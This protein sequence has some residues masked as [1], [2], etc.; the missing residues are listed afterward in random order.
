MTFSFTQRI[1]SSSR[2]GLGRFYR[3]VLANNGSVSYICPTNAGIAQLVE[4]NLAK[5]DV[6]GSNPVSRSAPVT[7]GGHSVI[8]P[9]VSYKYTSSLKW[10]RRPQSHQVAGLFFLGWI[11]RSHRDFFDLEVANCC[12]HMASYSEMIP[13]PYPS[14]KGE[15]CKTFMR[16][17]ESAR[18]LIGRP[19]RSRIDVSGCRGGGIGRRTGLKIL[20]AA[21]SVP[22][23]VRP[24][25]RVFGVPI[26]VEMSSAGG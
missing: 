20:R 13:A 11:V 19:V 22:V 10:P 25:V 23:Q 7:R 2:V 26:L 9:N 1:F 17:F 6:A 3:K 16:R 21:R 12:E 8:A 18:R 4:R 14:G 15:V 5:V 24:S